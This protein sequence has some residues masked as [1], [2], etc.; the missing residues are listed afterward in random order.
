MY[1]AVRYVKNR[2]DSVALSKFPNVGSSDE[3]KCKTSSSF[4]IDTGLFLRKVK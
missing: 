2:S 1:G 4:L 3:V